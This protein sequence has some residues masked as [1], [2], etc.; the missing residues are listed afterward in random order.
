MPQITVNRFSRS[1]EPVLASQE[2]QQQ[3]PYNDPIPPETSPVIDQPLNIGEDEFLSDLTNDK[4]VST[5]EILKNKKQQELLDKEQE[6]IQKKLDKE[7]KAMEAEQKKLD[8][9]KKDADK[10]MT[11]AIKQ[12]KRLTEDTLFS[13]EGT[14]LYGKDKLQLLAKIKQYKAL[15]PENKQL[16]SLK[17]KQ[18]ANVEELQSYLVECDAIIETGSIETFV[19]DAIL[20]TIKLG[21][22]ASVRT[23]FNIRGLSDLLKANPQFNLLCKQC[24]IKYKVFAAVPCEIQLLFVVVSTAYICVEKNKQSEKKEALLNKTIDASQ[25]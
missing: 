17:V 3:V 19:T 22:M 16:Q 15:F 9:L 10:E 1:K 7:K 4:F 21:E 20:Q 2:S 6:K 11:A 25:F 23:K 5:E 8:K 12:S 24:F 13:K 18:N 14:E